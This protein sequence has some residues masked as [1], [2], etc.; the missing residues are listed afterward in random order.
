MTEEKH[1]CKDCWHIVTRSY[2]LQPNSHWCSRKQF[3]IY[4]NV[5]RPHDW[6]C[7]DDGPEEMIPITLEELGIKEDDV[8]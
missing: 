5:E 7:W 4:Y 6:K 1:A 3:S 2:L 8:V